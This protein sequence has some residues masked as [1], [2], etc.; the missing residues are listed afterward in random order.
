L[1]VCGC[2]LSSCR[3]RGSIAVMEPIVKV[4]CATALPGT[5]HYLDLRSALVPM[6]AGNQ[7]IANEMRESN[8]ESQGKNDRREEEHSKQM[9]DGISDRR[10]EVAPEKNKQE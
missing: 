10:G 3:R 7:Q 8:R 5:G 4:T 6:K 2:C 9:E 1:Y